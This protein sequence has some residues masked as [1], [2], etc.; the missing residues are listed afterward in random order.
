MGAL[1]YDPEV[2]PGARANDFA[3]DFVEFDTVMQVQHSTS[4]KVTSFPV[5]SG[6]DLSDH[7]IPEPAEVTLTD[8]IVSKHPIQL[9]GAAQD[10]AGAVLSGQAP[11]AAIRNAVTGEDDEVVRTWQLLDKWRAAGTPLTLVTALRTYE[12]VSIRSLS[13]PDNP[14][15]LRGTV[16][17]R[18]LITAKTSTVAAP[19]TP[20]AA[21]KANAGAKANEQATEGEANNGT[22]LY[23]LTGEGLG[24]YFAPFSR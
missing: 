13:A 5:E 15:A 19:T 24:N 7:S 21:P 14:S 16:V 6:A 1:L 22:A 12:Q 18:E 8:A 20:R 23:N 17:C 3:F 2:R 11:D 4:A 9:F 10:V